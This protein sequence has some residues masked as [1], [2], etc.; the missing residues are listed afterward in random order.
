MTRKVAILLS[1]YNGGQY[2]KKQLDSIVHQ[3]GVDVHL[4]VRDDESTDDTLKCV[5]ALPVSKVTLYK[6]SNIGWRRSFF[7]LLM[8]TPI[9]EY[10]YFALADQDDIWDLDKI[11]IA[12]NFLEDAQ[13]TLYYSN[14]RMMDNLEIIHDNKMDVDYMGSKGG[15]ESFFDGNVMGATM[16]GTISFLNLI[17]R[18]LVIIADYIDSHDAF[19]FA[20]SNFLGKTVY[21]SDPHI[22]FRRHNN[23]ATGFLVGANQLKP[24]IIDR[25]RRYKKS[26]KNMY[27]T[28]AKML[29]D[30][31]YDLLDESQIYFLRDVVKSRVSLSTRFKLL[32]DKRFVSVGKY[33]SVK[34][35]LKIIQNN[36]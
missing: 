21:D 22:N 33:G 32:L 11:S 14:L 34:I 31:F 7:W 20:A 18:H 28:R 35:K 27:S 4:F 5:E 8:N 19:L 2:I 16:V 6:G 36:L 9:A 3:E 10:D 25:Y 24:S 29:L 1:T 30:S 23:N 17:R 12:I 13:A 15:I 26:P